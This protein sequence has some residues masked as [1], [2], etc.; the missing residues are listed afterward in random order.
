MIFCKFIR[1]NHD[2]WLWDDVLLGGDVSK[3]NLGVGEVRR[4]KG[5]TISSI[6]NLAKEGDGPQI[7]SRMSLM[8]ATYTVEMK[9]EYSREDE[10]DN[11]H[12]GNTRNSK[13]KVRPRGKAQVWYLMRP[14]Q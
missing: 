1:P 8:A 4:L 12:K 3:L 6:G 10:G 13:S 5:G 9:Q 14:S 7:I 2:L 11:K